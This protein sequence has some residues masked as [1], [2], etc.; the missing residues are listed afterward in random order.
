[1][2]RRPPR[3]TQSRSSAASDVYKRQ[4]F[5]DAVAMVATIALDAVII[6][7]P[8]HMHVEHVRV[9]AARGI[10]MLIEKP[11]APDTAGVDAIIAA[12]AAGGTQAMA[13]H[14]ERFEVGSAQL[15]MAVEQGLCG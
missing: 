2:I 11:V 13:A 15:K 3:S 9:C 1:M 12:V 8:E 10:S 7:S 6:A 4:V 14:V 5:P